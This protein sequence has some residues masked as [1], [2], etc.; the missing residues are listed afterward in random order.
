MSIMVKIYSKKWFQ[1]GIERELLHLGQISCF[2]SQKLDS[3]YHK[4]VWR[5]AM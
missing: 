2:K 3:C 1:N 4:C 5:W